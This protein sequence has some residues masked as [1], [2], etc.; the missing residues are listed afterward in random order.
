MRD[1]MADGNE[2]LRSRVN[3]GP[4]SLEICQSRISRPVSMTFRD[5]SEPQPLV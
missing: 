4:V 2:G 5:C 1:D 3:G